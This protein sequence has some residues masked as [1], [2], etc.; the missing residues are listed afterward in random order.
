MAKRK[1]RRSQR[2]KSVSWGRVFFEIIG[3]IVLAGML[4]GIYNSGHTLS[5]I[6]DAKP[7]VQLSAETTGI[8]RLEGPAATEKEIT[9][10]GT[11]RD[12]YALLQKEYF[13]WACGRGGCD[14]KIDQDAK[15]KIAGGI[16]VNDI[17]VQADQ[18][19]FYK[20]W[21]P[22]DSGTVEPGHILH[23]YAGGT[24]RPLLVE[25]HE[26]TAYGYH[27]VSSGERITVIGSA[28]NGQIQPLSIPGKE[29][30]VVLIGENIEQMAAKEKEARI[31]YIII[32]FLVILLLSPAMIGRFRRLRKKKT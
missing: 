13:Y 15:P 27:T 28:V 26:R 18:Y 32:G 1:H 5:V 11:L 7:V 20:S 2:K 10:S 3:W 6:R 9:E 31:F 14:Y 24:T 4:L 19:L 29:R 8:V 16:S 23:I 17:E 21:L 30:P 22:L 25:E 12:T